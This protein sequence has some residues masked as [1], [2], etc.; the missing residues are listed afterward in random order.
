M[1]SESKLLLWEYEPGV[2]ELSERQQELYQDLAFLIERHESNQSLMEPNENPS[3]IV[4]P[5]TTEAPKESQNLPQHLHEQRQHLYKVLS[6]MEN[7]KNRLQASDDFMMELLDTLK[8]VKDKTDAL[9]GDCEDLV[10]VQQQL[11]NKAD[12]LH[13]KME[14]LLEYDRLAVQLNAP[15]F[16]VTTEG[17]LGLLDK[18]QT[19]TAY[20]AANPQ[21]KEASL[22]KTR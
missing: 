19:N 7:V 2:A 4:L 5:S 8:T 18:L 15:G 14:P 13:T 22:F 10:H 12:L 1:P 16:S 21:F 20:L 3:K 9:Y 6:D 11:T 17:F